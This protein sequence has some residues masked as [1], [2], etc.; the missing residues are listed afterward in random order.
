LRQEILAK[1]PSVRQT[2]FLIKRLNKKSKP[3]TPLTG[4]RAYYEALATAFSR[5]L[6]GMK[7][8]IHTRG[9]LGKLEIFY[10]HQEELE[11]LM[12]KLGVER[13]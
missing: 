4:D 12:T 13:I 10:N 7:V 8:K 3:K 5:Q 2:E 1:K 9:R 11:L 6:Q